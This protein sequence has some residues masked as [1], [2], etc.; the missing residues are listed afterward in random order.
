[1]VLPGK[2]SNVGTEA[3]LNCGQLENMEMKALTGSCSFGERAFGSC[4]QLK[5]V[6]LSE[7]VDAISDQMFDKCTMLESIR[8]PSTC[9]TIGQEAFNICASLHSIVIPEGVKLIKKQAFTNSG[10][11]D[12]YVMA[13]SEDKVPAIYSMG[14]NWGGNDGTFGSAM[15]TGNSHDP[16]DKHNNSVATEKDRINNKNND[17]ATILSWYQ[18]DFSDGR[19]G[20]GGGDCLVRLHYPES[21]RYFY[22]GYE[23]PVTDATWTPTANDALS[24]SEITAKL[25]KIQDANANHY[26]SEGYAGGE[27]AFGPDQYGNYWPSRIDYL[28]R[29]EAGDP[30]R[31]KDPKDQEKYLQEPSSLGWRQLPLQTSS[32]NDDFI[33]TKEYDD[34]WYTMCFPWDM[35][36]NTLFSTFNQ[37]C[38]IVE[39]VGVEVVNNSDDHL[40]NGDKNLTLIF[41]FDEVAKANYMTED[42]SKKYERVSGEYTR[43]ETVN[44]D[45]A[46]VKVNYYTY[47]LTNG[48]DDG[49][50]TVYWP[51]GLPK[52]KSTYTS[53]QKE[54]VKRY[55][56]IRHLMVFAGHPYMIHPSVGKG[57]ENVPEN[58]ENRTVKCYIAGVKKQSGD[59]VA[60][61][62]ANA[63]T[64]FTTVGGKFQNMKEA[65]PYDGGKTNYTF[66]GYIDDLTNGAR[67]MM[68]DDDHPYAYFLALDPTQSYYPKYYRKS[69]DNEKVASWSQYS[70]IIRPDAAAIADIEKY[71]N[72]STNGG[73]S[74]AKPFDVQ[75]GKWEVVDATAIE[76]I[77]SEAERKNQ[78]VEQ[79]HLNVVFNIKGQVIR[80]GADSVEGLPKGLY[81]VNGKKYM[82]K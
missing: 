82:V 76:E 75:F 81:I 56:S 6:T 66:I 11:T 78:P 2:L 42:H 39:F 33:F 7:G 14:S 60:L 20:V 15:V 35:D 57:P 67:K 10:I 80:E 25:A 8:I 46:D 30:T 4:F 55:E 77:I 29:L 71:M 12:V 40:Q 65:D 70:A 49:Y 36:D 22:D 23:N 51:T 41:H 61:A 44:I 31:Y 9:E 79:V 69:K 37:K 63:V 43:T 18:E 64:K 32:K 13:T 50:T 62:N 28:L 52:D 3:F 73:S 1:M 5:H 34:T 58:A 68:T 21:M 59:L 53:E 74:S 38:E 54:M 47:E 24:S 27:R 48:S 45:G 19:L 16:Y 26:I 72:L 17:E